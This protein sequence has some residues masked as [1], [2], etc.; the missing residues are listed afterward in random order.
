MMT[1]DE[2]LKELETYGNPATKKVFMKHGAKE[3]FFGVKVADLKKI[4]KKVKK[5][6]ELALA[7]Y[8]SKNLDAMYL[9][10]LIADEDKVTK[11]ELEKWAKNASWHMVSE[12]TVPWV[13]ADSKHGF[14]LALKWITSKQEH[15][16]STGWATLSSVAAVKS[17][18]ELDIEKYSELL[19]QVGKNIHNAPNRVRYTMNGF[20]IAVGSYIPALTKKANKIAEKIGKVDV[21]MGGIACKVPLATTYIQKVVD[22]GSIGKKRKTARC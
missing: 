20:V 10:G 5:D 2:V 3:P 15:I 11:A 17:D 9:A 6:H 19:D 14:D 18:E 21:E 7:L 1:K 16:A 22:R 4:Q 13:A 12:Y 8:D